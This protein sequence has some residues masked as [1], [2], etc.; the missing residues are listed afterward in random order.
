MKD[1]L[2]AIIKDIA[3]PKLLEDF[4]GKPL[5]TFPIPAIDLATLDPS[6]PPGIEL[7]FALENLYRKEGFTVVQG[8]LE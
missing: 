8:H 4:V 6:L 5:G 1:G 7:K 2:E 3:L